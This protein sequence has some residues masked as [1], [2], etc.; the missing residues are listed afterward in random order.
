MDLSIEQQR[1]K[2]LFSAEEMRSDFYVNQVQPVLSS[3]GLNNGQVNTEILR[4]ALDDRLFFGLINLTNSYFYH[5]EK[6]DQSLKIMYEKLRQTAKEL[7]PDEGFIE[8]KLG[9]SD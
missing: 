3:S 7:Y 8:F 5:L 4:D 2:Q 9:V 6:T 1:F